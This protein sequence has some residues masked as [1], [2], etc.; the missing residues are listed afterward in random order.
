MPSRFVLLQPNIREFLTILEVGKFK[1]KVPEDLVSGKSLVSTSKISPWGSHL[2]QGRK[3]VST[4]SKIVEAEN[5]TPFFDFIY[6][7]TFQRMCLWP[8]I[9][10][11]QAARGSQMTTC[12]LHICCC[13]CLR[14]EGGDEISL[15][16]AWLVWNLL[17]S[18]G[19]PQTQRFACLCLSSV[20]LNTHTTTP[21]SWCDI[22][23]LMQHIQNTSISMC[24]QLHVMAPICNPSTHEAEIAIR[25]RSAWTTESEASLVYRCKSLS[26]FM[27]WKYFI[28]SFQNEWH[29]SGDYCIEKE[30][31]LKNVL[32]TP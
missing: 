20:R 29:V 30:C 15:C 18:L 24:H 3:C 5:Q 23:Y 28:L 6:I 26:P 16:S 27:G 31:Y 25:L 9:S 32:I 1:A 10:T 21:S 14:W 19:W 11:S 8:F 13:C 22:L 7:F 17:Y 2:L 4:H 12:I